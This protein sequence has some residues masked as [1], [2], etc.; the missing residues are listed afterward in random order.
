MNQ[1][2]YFGRG[3]VGRLR[4]VLNHFGASRVLLVTGRHSF[5]TSGAA[6]M[7]EQQ[8]QGC[9]LSRYSDFSENPKLQDAVAG[10]GVL[11]AASYD[12]IL[13]VGGGSALDMA[14]LINILGAQTHD[15]S[16]IVTGAAP[17][18][19]RGLP[20]V[21]LPTTSGSGSEATHFAVVYVDRVKHSVTSPFLLPD[22]AIVDP[23]LTFSLPASVTAV[24]GMDALTQAVESY[25][26]IHSTDASRCDAARAMSLAFHHLQCAVQTPTPGQ[27]HAMSKAAH[28]AGRAINVTKTTACHAVS[29]P[30]TSHFGVP[31]G[32]AVALTLGP[33]LAYNAAVSD[34]DV[35]DPR[36]AAYV[37][38][39]I[40]DLVRV[41]GCRDLDHCREAIDVL[42][43]SVGL[44]TRL[45]DLG[46]PRD[47]AMDTVL[48]LVNVQRLV[49]NP[50]AVNHDSLRQIIDAIR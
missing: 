27:R 46:I 48:R 16:A 45:S 26:C 2:V 18:E 12:L 11:R 13:A 34:A 42:M 35:T 6:A 20:L 30:L 4:R 29:Y 36:G 1:Q 23:A 28:L 15:P 9:Q 5:A 21:A 37:R 38:K 22:V 14:K 50:R 33:F 40:D 7:L 17:I 24:S 43:R 19:R 32:H 3:A 49:N 47:A 41:L 25:W 8:L 39:T 44:S 31:H 10:V